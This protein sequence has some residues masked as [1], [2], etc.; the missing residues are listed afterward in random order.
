MN[1]SDP[2]LPWEE[3]RGV[4]PVEGSACAKSEKNPSGHAARRP[5]KQVD[6][7]VKAPPPMALPGADRATFVALGLLSALGNTPRREKIRQTTSRLGPTHVALRFV[8]A[9][10]PDGATPSQ[11]VLDELR[12][13]NDLVRLNIS[14]TPFRC[15]FKYVLWFDLAR[16]AFPSARYFGAGDDDAYI[17]IAHFEADLRIAAAQV[18]YDAPMLWGMIQWRSHYDKVTHDTSTGFMGWGCADAQAASVRR[19]MIACKAQL[20]EQP[21]LREQLATAMASN[22]SHRPTK[23]KASASVAAHVAKLPACASFAA[24]AKRLHAVVSDRVDWSLPPFPVPNGPLFAVSRSLAD[25]LSEDLDVPVTGSRAWVYELERTPLALR[26]F[27]SVKRGKTIAEL[28]KRRCWPNSDSTLGLFVARAALRHDVRVT[29]VNTPLGI[30]HFPWPV[31]SAERGFSNRSIVFHGAKK[32]TSRAWG[33]AEAR[34]SGEFIPLN[35][36]CD[37][38]AEMGWA[39]FEPSAFLK[40]RCCGHRALKVL[41]R[42]ERAKKNAVA[43]AGSAVQSQ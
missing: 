2:D 15:G 32:P 19:S 34:G 39:T 40:W 28:A 14:D 11:S 21:H 27:A 8:L 16:R 41:R 36:T 37:A 3:G 18:G 1:I 20:S 42:A 33:V 25:L 4:R 23:P 35:R 29:M 38:C 43:A 9:A 31:Y 10:Q 26:H 22:R 7:G 13:N 17:Q 6:R 30:Q 12:S 5:P 24:N